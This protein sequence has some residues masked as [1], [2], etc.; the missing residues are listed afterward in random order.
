MNKWENPQHIDSFL[1][2]LS[3]LI[4]GK[5]K[6]MDFSFTWNDQNIKKYSQWFCFNEKNKNFS[7]SKERRWYKNERNG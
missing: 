7:K 2:V 4:D 5:E 3:E 6:E 1:F